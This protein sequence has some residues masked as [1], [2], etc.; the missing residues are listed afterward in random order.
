LATSSIT[1]PLVIL[2]ASGGSV[3][4]SNYTITVNS[5]IDSNYNGANI[6]YV[7]TASSS[8][9]NTVNVTGNITVSGANKGIAIGK[10][11]IQ[12]GNTVVLDIIGNI[13]QQGAI[14][15]F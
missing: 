13:A 2:K 9:A 10:T 8:F 7:G 14:F 15:Q 1:N 11:S 6:F 5:N 3:Q 4:D 12:T